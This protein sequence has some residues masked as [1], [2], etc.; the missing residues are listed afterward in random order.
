[1][2]CSFSLFGHINAAVTGLFAESQSGMSAEYF[3]Q[4][5]N[6]LLNRIKP[7]TTLVRVTLRSLSW[8]HRAATGSE[9][10]VTL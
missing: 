6:E 7:L 8:H 9:V 2:V 4:R 3:K 1:M 10:D 5:N